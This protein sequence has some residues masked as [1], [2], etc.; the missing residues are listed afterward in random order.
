MCI[1]DLQSL[2]WC[3]QCNL[4]CLRYFS[5][6]NSATLV[7]GAVREFPIGFSLL[8]VLCCWVIFW[9]FRPLETIRWNGLKILNERCLFVFF[10]SFFVNLI[11]F[12]SLIQVW[13]MC[14]VSLE[15]H[16]NFYSLFCLV[17]ANCNGSFPD[18]NGLEE[19]NLDHSLEASR[20]S[21]LVRTVSLLLLLSWLGYSSAV[22]KQ[23]KEIQKG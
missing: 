13:S 8:S 23:L 10:F 17:F 14:G 9:L 11:T 1:S 3:C 7:L 18:R 12:H 22:F 15:C 4:T 5:Y 2:T 16:L 20:R 21:K 19:E 6:C